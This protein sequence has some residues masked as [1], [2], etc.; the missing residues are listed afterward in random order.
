VAKKSGFFSTFPVHPCLSMR[1]C[2]LM[3]VIFERLLEPI[4]RGARTVKAGQ[5]GSERHADSSRL[6]I[7][8]LLVRFQRGA[9]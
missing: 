3:P 2:D 8:G 1:F 5:D 7:T 4:F 6:L 9:F